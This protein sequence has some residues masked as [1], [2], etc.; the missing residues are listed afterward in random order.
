LF[1]VISNRLKPT[2]AAAATT[3]VKMTAN[4]AGANVI[5][6]PWKN[7]LKNE[8]YRTFGIFSFHANENIFFLS[9]EREM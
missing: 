3:A 2:E 6:F 5:Q 9:P 4:F 7:L 8:S 1:A